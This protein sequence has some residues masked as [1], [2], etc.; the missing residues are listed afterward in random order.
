MAI[1]SRS[2]RARAGTS[3]SVAGGR[4]R[5]HDPGRDLLLH[6][7]G[8]SMLFIPVDGR[9]GDPGLAGQVLEAA[10][11]TRHG[12][13]VALGQDHTL[14]VLDPEEKA[15]VIT[16]ETYSTPPRVALPRPRMSYFPPHIRF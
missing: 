3:S 15:G 5:H 11:L 4:D 2:R 16:Q 13:H 1:A 8:V 12:R 6:A 14:P 7:P 10:G 9:Q